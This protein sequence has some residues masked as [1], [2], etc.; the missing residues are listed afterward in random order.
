M[1]KGFIK[2]KQE[3]SASKFYGLHAK[4]TL[5]ILVAQLMDNSYLYF[6]RVRHFSEFPC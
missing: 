6:R 2:I 4:T 1:E 5:S 3:T